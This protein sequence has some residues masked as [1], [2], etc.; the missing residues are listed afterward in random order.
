MEYLIGTFLGGAIALIGALVGRFSP[1]EKAGETFAAAEE[2]PALDGRSEDLLRQWN[3]L[4][5][6]CG[7]EQH[8]DD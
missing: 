7:K 6:Y 3:N 8:D 2:A 1:P 4:L 5:S